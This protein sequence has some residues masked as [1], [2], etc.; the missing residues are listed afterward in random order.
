MQ[1]AALSLRQRLGRCL[2]ALCATHGAVSVADAIRPAAEWIAGDALVLDSRLLHR[3][4]AN[5]SLGAPVALLVLRYDLAPS[6]P[7]GCSRRWLL[8][9][10]QLGAVLH[11]LFRVYAAV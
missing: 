10:T 11:A 4:L 8:H 7:P 6:P 5:D 2:K 3:G 9:M 1:W